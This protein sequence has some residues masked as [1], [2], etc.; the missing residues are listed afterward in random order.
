MLKHHYGK[1]LLAHENDNDF[2]ITSQTDVL[3]LM[4]KEK[5]EVLRHVKDNIKRYRK[6]ISYHENVIETKK[7]ELQALEDT[8]ILIKNN[9]YS[10]SGLDIEDIL[11]A[12][13]TVKKIIK[14]AHEHINDYEEMIRN[15]KL[16]CEMLELHLGN[17][18]ILKEKK[19]NE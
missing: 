19:E 3:G 13:K 4:I 5:E 8:L 10:E 9:E 1:V 6:H 7:K 17:L 2:H 16:E 14:E 11:L 12:Q 15:E 18:K